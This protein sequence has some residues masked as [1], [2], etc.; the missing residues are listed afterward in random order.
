M[1]FSGRS[2]VKGWKGFKRSFRYR[3]KKAQRARNIGGLNFR[4]K[5]G[6]RLHRRFP[7]GI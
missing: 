6:S 7:H 4:F 3:G 5:R 1:R 2:R